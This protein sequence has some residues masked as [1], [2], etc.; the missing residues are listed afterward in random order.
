MANLSKITLPNN[1]TYDL[2]DSAARALLANKQDTLVSGTNIKTLNNT[3]LLGSGNIAIKQTTLVTTTV[4]LLS[5]GWVSKQQTVTPQVNG[6][7]VDPSAYDVVWVSPL[8]NSS[9]D[10]VADYSTA[11]IYLH[12]VGTQSLTFYCNSAPSKNIDVV[13]VMEVVS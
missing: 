10:Y 6:T 2:A 13:V 3:S 8:V 4:T 9:N 11:G 7:N 12:D 5:S 1:V